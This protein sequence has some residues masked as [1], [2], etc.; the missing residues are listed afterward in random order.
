MIHDVILCLIVILA[1][2]LLGYITKTNI[3]LWAIAGSYFLGAFV[4]GIKPSDIVTMWP[5]KLFL[6]LFSVTFF[7]GYAVLNGSLE[8]LSL[9]VVYA[10]RKIPW[11]IAIALFLIAIVISG[12]GAGDGATVMLVP[13]AISIAK[14][15]GMNYFLAAVSVVSGICI[16]G[17]SPISTIGIFIRELADQVGGYGPDAV[18][19][20]G[21]RAMLQSF[22]LFVLVFIFSYILFKGYKVKIP[23]LEKPAP[24]HSQQRKTIVVIGFFVGIL[25]LAPLLKALFPAVPFFI[26]LSG[27]MY[28]TFVAF[29][30]AIAA[31]ILRLGDEKSVFSRVPLSALTTICGMGMLI[32]VAGKS[33][34]IEMMSGYLSTSHLSGTLVQVCLALFSGIMSLFVSGFVVNTT[35][36]A[37]VPGLSA[38]LGFNPGLLFSA[39]AVGSIATAVSPFSGTGGLVIASIDEEDNRGRIFNRLLVW[40]FINLILYIILVMIGI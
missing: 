32:A 10:S 22:T 11:F 37:L 35:F 39:I 16:G 24:F 33:G 12:I 38:G 15:T 25:L 36:F 6:M 3:G 9:K 1:A 7:Y 20:F 26:K 4:L 34:A 27:K 31:S 30:A 2:I 28:L 17:F 18:N 19:A 8:K 14:L 40:P 29:L 13:I 5:I 21:H 23:V